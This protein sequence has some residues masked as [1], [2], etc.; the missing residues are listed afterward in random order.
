M[1]TEQQGQELLQLVAD[2]YCEWAI[3]SQADIFWTTLNALFE[4][5]KEIDSDKMDEAWEVAMRHRT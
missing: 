3:S 5:A 2:V 4:K 1:M